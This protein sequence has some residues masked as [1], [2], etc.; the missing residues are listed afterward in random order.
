MPTALILPVDAEQLAGSVLAADEGVFPWIDAM[1]VGR[2]LPRAQT[3]LSA[4]EFADNGVPEHKEIKQVHVKR[5]TQ[6]ARLLEANPQ[7][8][9]CCQPCWRRHTEN[10]WN[11][12]Q[13]HNKHNT[14]NSKQQRQW[15]TT[16]EDRQN[17]TETTN[18]NGGKS[19]WRKQAANAKEFRTPS[20]DTH[21]T[22]SEQ[23]LV[24]NRGHEKQDKGPKEQE[25]TQQTNEELFNSPKNSE[26]KHQ[27]NE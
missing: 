9:C 22:A 24:D 16:D 12:D 23:W 6:S 19:F 5:R 20:C 26:S 13:A 3:T 1:M 7:T 17:P 2:E 14:A 27:R 21:N 25:K 10:A 15:K 8:I 4:I 11:T 18:S